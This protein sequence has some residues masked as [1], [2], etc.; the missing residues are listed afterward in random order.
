LLASFRSRWEEAEAGRGR[1]RR[2]MG[3]ATGSRRERGR[4]G[5]ER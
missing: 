4:R 1:R 3:D 2:R 5:E